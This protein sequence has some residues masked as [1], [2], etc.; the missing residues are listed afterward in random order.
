MLW[1]WQL[2]CWARTVNVRGI[3]NSWLR[4]TSKNIKTVLMIHSQEILMSMDGRHSMK[5]AR[6]NK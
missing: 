1:L 2:L 6:R 5:F 3:E 4:E